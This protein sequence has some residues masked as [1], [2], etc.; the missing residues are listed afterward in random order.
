MQQSTQKEDKNIIILGF[1]R[2]GSTWISEV[3]NHDSELVYNHE[4]DNEIT[5]FLGLT[6]KSNMSRFPYLTS[7]DQNPNFKKLFSLALSRD[8]KTLRDY[9]NQALFKF[10][11]YNKEKIQQNLKEINTAN[12]KDH[13]LYHILSNAVIGQ[14]IKSRSLIKS[15][16]ALL[17]FEFLDHHFDFIPIIT[18]RHPLNVFSSYVS[19]KLP[20]ANRKLYKKKQL[21][22][23][24]DIDHSISS[25]YSN[26]FQSGF[27]MGVFQQYIS[28]IT[29]KYNH[30]IEINYEN[31]IEDPIE[32]YKELFNQLDLDFNSNDKNFILSKFKDGKGYT[33]SRIPSKQKEIWKSRLNT[34]Q[35][36]EFLAG[37]ETAKGEID[38]NF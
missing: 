12:S 10:F 32:N 36:D 7:K 8:I 13:F 30:I 9:R 22:R 16:H 31:F 38:F 3:L 14:K 26:E 11:R 19:M 25:N 2:S 35:I 28:E 17:A 37:Y 20:D 34:R 18:N 21:L 15:V 4:P 1:P 29:D 33:T 27:Q 23:R 6:L 24:L 5:S